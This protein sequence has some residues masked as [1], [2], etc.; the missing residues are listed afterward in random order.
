MTL[1]LEAVLSLR[2]VPASVR[3][4]TGC[5]Q[6]N[7]SSQYLSRMYHLPT[8]TPSPKHLLPWDHRLQVTGGW[9][10]E[11]G[12]GDGKPPGSWV[13]ASEN[14]NISSLAYREPSLPWHC[15]NSMGMAGLKE[16]AVAPVWLKLQTARGSSPATSAP[17]PEPR[18]RRVFH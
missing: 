7:T 2:F 5:L 13:L 3:A 15:G 1:P 8:S 6:L 10:T 14:T 12:S 18:V 16:F 9:V 17:L 4:E 11:M